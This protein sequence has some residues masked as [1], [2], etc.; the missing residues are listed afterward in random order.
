MQHSILRL[1]DRLLADQFG[2]E[3]W[4]RWRAI[5]K[6]T[7]GES[8]SKADLE[9]FEELTGRKTAPDKPVRELW[10][11]CGRR[12]GK[13]MISALVAVFLATCR[14]YKL[15]PGEQ[16]VFMVIAA[17]RRQARVV[18]RYIGGLLHSH[19]VLEA[20]IQS[21]TKTAFGLVGGIAIEIHTASYRTIRG[22]SVI[23]AVLDE[24]AFFRTDDVAE[25]DREVLNALRPAMAT[26]PDSL[27]LCLSS[28][29]ARRGVLYEA[30]R[31][32]YGVPG[33]ILV[34]KSPTRALNPTVPQ[35]VID[36]A[37]DEDDAAAR[38][39][40]GAEFRRDVES[41]IT[42]EAVN[43]AVVPGRLELPPLEGCSYSGFLDFA[44]GS[45]GDAAALGI[46]HTEHL[47]GR[48]TVVLDVVREIRPPFP[49]QEVCR[50]FAHTLR[51]YGVVSG[52]PF[53]R[54]SLT[55]HR[56]TIAVNLDG[57]MAVTHAFL[58]DLVAR[59]E[60]HIVNVVSA[61]AFVALPFGASYAASKWGALG[62]SESLRHEMLALGNRHVKVTT[63]C[64]AYVD[65]GMFA[66][67]KA[68][69]FT[70]FLTPK[71]LAAATVRAIE[72]D[73]RV[74]RIPWSVQLTRLGTLMPARMFD[75][76]GRLFGINTS[77]RDWTGHE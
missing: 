33:E 46:A 73:K 50:D 64:P 17:D 40:F 54:V 22:Y 28:P 36:R 52:G 57:V 62:F 16:G 30:Y 10:C 19:P 67:A 74:L 12:S 47:E 18:H 65:T 38:A 60:A 42:A 37:Y 2:G 69:P 5:L 9:T 24:I 31:R 56:R 48:D 45:G 61:S 72:R 11:V 43:A 68:P 58:P 7:F 23:G 4:S 32:H 25:P 41:F 6:A 20:M 27:L 29:Y 71:A 14:Q 21:E 55:A 63:V 1:M 8:M 76:V 66:G 70:R 13:S 75:I 26:I 35:E 3:S 44:G 77:M 15:A 49:P 39:E 59:P 51:L 53:T 34:I